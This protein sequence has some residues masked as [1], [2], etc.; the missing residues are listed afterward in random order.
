MRLLVCGG[1]D[2]VHQERVFAALDLLHHVR[3]ITLLI[4]GDAPGADRLAAKW[5][6]WRAIPRAPYPAQ[7]DRYGNRAGIIRNQA[8]ITDGKPDGVCAFPGGVGTADMVSRALEAGLRV[9]HPYPQMKKDPRR[10]WRPS[11][12]R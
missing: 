2:F 4:Y 1:R 10:R 7:W 5:A 11:G 8:M 9:W 12:D 3:P 6:E